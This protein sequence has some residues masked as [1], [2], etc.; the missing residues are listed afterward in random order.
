MKKAARP[1]GA[2]L[3]VRVQPRARRSE[4]VGWHGT[5]LRVRVTAAPTEG[6]ANHAVIELLAEALGLPR[7]SIELV[8]GA[9]GRDKLV[10]VGRHSLEEIRA[11]LDGA[12]A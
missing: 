7:S 11:R 9:S 1:E 3:P 4:V 6:R 2:L 5:T 8:S 10:R 12:H